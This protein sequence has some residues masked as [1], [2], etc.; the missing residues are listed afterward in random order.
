MKKSSDQKES[1]FKQMFVT[2]TFGFISV[3]Q[4]KEFWKSTADEFNGELTIKKTI[5]GDLEKLILKLPCK[6][7]TIQFTESDTH[8]LKIT[9]E[10]EA[11]LPF[12]FM[13]SYEDTLEKLLKFFGKQDIQVGDEE[14]DSKYLIQ[15]KNTNIVKQILSGNNV[16]TI[17]LKNNVFSFGCNYNKKNNTLI[18][19]SLVSR[20]VNSKKDLSE[21]Y[22]LFCLTIDKMKDAGLI[23][24]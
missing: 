21:L 13:I 2:R 14:F 10:L 22:K 24:K 6:K 17:L 3:S 11:E 8:P 15:G 4:K 1:L 18:L 16:K 23:K 12:E 7:H 5:A 20:T 9:T 19:T